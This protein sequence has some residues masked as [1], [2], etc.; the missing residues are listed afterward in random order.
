[1][2]ANYNGTLFKKLSIHP[3]TVHIEDPNQLN[4]P[5]SLPK[6]EDRKNPFLIGNDISEWKADAKR[7]SKLG[8]K[9]RKAFKTE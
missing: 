5:K 3:T 8:V 1:M 7:L 4:V 9:G 2:P 6:D